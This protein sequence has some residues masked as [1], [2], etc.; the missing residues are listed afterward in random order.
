MRI[1]LARKQISEGLP[2]NANRVHA[3]ASIGNPVT[4]GWRDGDGGR[5]YVHK[6]KKSPSPFPGRGDLL[7]RNG[8]QAV[9]ATRSS[10][11]SFA[12]RPAGSGFTTVR[13]ALC[14]K[15]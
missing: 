5:Q 1:Q 4:S 10:T 14:Q 15:A 9:T 7:L 8:R 11:G 12:W 3:A 2:L 13:R 6:A